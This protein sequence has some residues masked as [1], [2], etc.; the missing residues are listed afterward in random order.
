MNMRG[1]GLIYVNH[2]YVVIIYAQM[3]RFTVLV[4]MMYRTFDVIGCG[5]RQLHQLLW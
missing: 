2:C 5:R 4:S 3:P 1:V